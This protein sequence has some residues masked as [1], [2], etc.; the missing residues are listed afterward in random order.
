MEQAVTLEEYENHK[1]NCGESFE[2]IRLQ[3]GILNR[4]VL[5]EPA[6]KQK[7]LVEMT[8]AMYESVVIAKGGER[9]FLTLV[10]ISGGILTLVAA[11]WAVIGV[12]KRIIN[13]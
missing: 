11:F 2:D 5:G 7:G 10:K 1:K 12:A 4:A 8:S 9:L 13:N 3:L 6:L